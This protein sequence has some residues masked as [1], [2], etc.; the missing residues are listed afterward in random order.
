[1]SEQH[2]TK[3]W[4]WTIIVQHPNSR[5]NVFLFRCVALENCLLSRLKPLDV[6]FMKRLHDKVNIIPMIA[7]ADTLTPD[8]CR[9]FKKTV[10][11]I[12]TF[13]DFMSRLVSQQNLEVIAFIM[14]VFCCRY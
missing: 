8:E 1:M 10:S 5:L 4:Q 11:E 14:L 9:E 6:E 12:C 13:R 3:T 2:V 7:K